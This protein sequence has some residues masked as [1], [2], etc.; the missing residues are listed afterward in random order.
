MNQYDV[1]VYG[2]LFCDLIFT[3][4]DRLPE[5]GTEIF[6]GDFTVAPG[7]SAIVA[8]GLQKLGVRVGLIADLGDDPFSQIMRG[9]LDDLH[10]DRAL[11]REHPHPLPQLTVALSFPHDRAFITR[12]EQPH[13]AHDLRAILAQHRP[14]HLH[15]GS[16]LAAFD[17]P[18][19][20]RIAHEIEATVSMDPGWDEVA[21]RDPRLREMLNDLDYFLPSRSEL[22]YMMETEDADKALSDGI[23]LMPYGAIIMKDGANGAF[24]HGQRMKAHVP[25]LTVQ[26]VDT[27]GAGDAF[28]AGFIYGLINGHPIEECMRYGV[29]CGGLT[30][31]VAGGATGTPTRE[32]VEQWL[33]KLRS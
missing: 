25:A 28:D 14:R 22:C 21:L 10:I 33:S 9:M 31:T 29:V 27:T 26:P 17:A 24:A 19:A 4:L 11:I 1:L 8:A 6:A 2:P 13:T 12:F 5:L 15:I 3:D 23:A 7:G 18:D 30:T 20:C 32:D 16:F